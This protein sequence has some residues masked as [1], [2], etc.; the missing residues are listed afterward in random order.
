MVINQKNL[1]ANGENF[2][3][4]SLTNGLGSTLVLCSFGASIRDFM[5]ADKFG[6]VKSILLFPESYENYISP[7]D[8]H[9]KT[10]GRTA[11]RVAGATYTLD[12]QTAYLDKNSADVDNLHGGYKG[13]NAKNFESSIVERADYVDVIFNALS[14]EGEGGHIGNVNVDITYRFYE[15]LNT[16]D[17][18]YSA[19]ADKSVLLNLTNHAYFNLSGNLDK[20]YDT[21]IFINANV[22]GKTNERYI[23]TEK[24]PVDLVTDFTKPKTIGEHLFDEKLQ[25]HSYGYDTQ[26]FLNEEDFSLVSASGYYKETGLKLNVYTTYPVINFYTNNYPCEHLLANGVKDEKYMAFCLECQFHPDGVHQEKTRNGIVR[27]GEK[28]FE[29]IRFEILTDKE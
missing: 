7:E 1:V 15:K 19:S 3:E 8:Y 9:G 18:I 2:S 5:V 24:L 16:V 13:F 23:I 28:Y 20:V 21:E 10:L 27:K 14:P 26:Y 6:K 17:I 22:Y 25:A 12:G 4:I 29:K 11:G